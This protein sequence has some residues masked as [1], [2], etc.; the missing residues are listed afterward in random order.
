MTQEGSKKANRLGS[1]DSMKGEFPRFPFCFIDPRLSAGE[2]GN[3]E[4]STDVDQKGPSNNTPEKGQLARQKS[5]KRDHP[6]PQKRQTTGKK[7][8]PISTTDSRLA[9]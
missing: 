4:T 8:C 3:L 7:C 1:W 9:L 6:T 5:F 2:A